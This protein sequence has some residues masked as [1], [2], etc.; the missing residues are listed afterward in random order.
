[1]TTTLS[2]EGIQVSSDK[3]TLTNGTNTQYIRKNGILETSGYYFVD[4]YRFD[5]NKTILLMPIAVRSTS[6]STNGSAILNLLTNA[7]SNNSNITIE[8]GNS[9]VKYLN[10]LQKVLALKAHNYSYKLMYSS[11]AY[12]STVGT[13]EKN[14]FLAGNNLSSS[15][16]NLSN[17]A[18]IIE[19]AGSGSVTLNFNANAKTVTLISNKKSNWSLIGIYVSIL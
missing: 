14:T 12:N 1:M 9:S 15:S 3:L 6:T 16:Y 2:K 13:N 7:V 8:L 18:P 10:A 19:T 5:K 4:G 17:K 11:V